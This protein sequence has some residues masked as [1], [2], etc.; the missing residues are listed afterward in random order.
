MPRKQ[1]GTGKPKAI[2][3]KANGM[4]LN[5]E[6]ARFNMIEQQI[7]TWDVLDQRVLETLKTVPREE[8]VPST[9]RR[10]AFMD[11]RI[12]LGHDQVM[13][14]PVEEG[15]LLQ[16]LQ[17]EPGQTVLEIGTGSGFLA[18]CLS[19]LGGLVT[20]LEIFDDLAESA[21]RRLERAGVAN[22]SV[23]QADA[24]DPTA[25]PAGEFDCVVVT[26][27]S[28]M[29]PAL[30]KDKVALGG[31]LFAIQGAPPAMEAVCLHREK[32][33]QW[34]TDSLFETDLPRLVGAEDV[35]HFEF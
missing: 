29:V 11:V 28:A 31:R 33:D 19:D 23:M 8:F 9:H 21:S 18:A 24:F 32:T 10:M 1:P 30:L 7:R 16:A 14:K 27:S 35:P 6:Q 12:P 20:S 34:H 3:E 25:L 17:L 13:M 15:R 4:A 26:G 5:I 2:G 22:V